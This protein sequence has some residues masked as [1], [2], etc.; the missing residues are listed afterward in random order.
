M[1]DKYRYIEKFHN[2][3][4]M[5]LQNIEFYYF[6]NILD[7]DS[8][9]CECIDGLHAGDVTYQKILLKINT[10]NPTSSLNSLLAIDLIKNSVV[11]YSGKALTMFK[12]NKFKSKEVDFLE[13]GCKK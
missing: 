1:L 12:D 6:Q 11:R 8:N 7:L 2:F 5:R 9:D 4:K 3:L 13:I 10:D